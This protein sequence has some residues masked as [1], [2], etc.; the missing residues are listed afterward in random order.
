MFHVQPLSRV[1]IYSVH[2][3]PR[4]YCNGIFRGVDPKLTSEKLEK[5]PIQST[6]EVP[7]QTF[8]YSKCP[9]N[10]N[11]FPFSISQRKCS[12]LVFPLICK[13]KELIFPFLFKSMFN[14]GAFAI[15]LSPSH[16]LSQISIISWPITFLSKLVLCRKSKLEECLY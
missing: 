3:F 2:A 13:V 9:C 15:S 5:I 7:E 6:F 11:S 8:T 14:M 10:W 1:I 12:L 4:Y 16:L